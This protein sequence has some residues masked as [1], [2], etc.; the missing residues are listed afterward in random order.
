MVAVAVALVA[1]ALLYLV[2]IEP[3]W[4]ARARLARELPRLQEQMAELEALHDEARLLRQ[5]GFG[6]D[7]DTSLQAGVE[8]S[9]GRAGLLAKLRVESGSRISVS[10]VGVQ[11]QAWFAWM[12]EF[13]RES[14]VRVARARI[15]RS[16]LPGTVDAEVGFEL[17]SR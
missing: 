1:V 7:T 3:A 16:G 6:T 5:Q 9:L 11:A 8:R 14:R 13:A 2:G 12:E 10:A 4:T 17:P 15:T